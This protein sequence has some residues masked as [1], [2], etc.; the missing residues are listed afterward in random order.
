[1]HGQTRYLVRFPQLT[2]ADFNLWR[3]Y[4]DADFDEGYSRAEFVRSPRPAVGATAPPHLR[5]SVPSASSASLRQSDGLALTASQKDEH[6]FS[7]MY[8]G[9]R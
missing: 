6:P 8:S 2:D 3:V 4:A 1:M 5:D 9:Q 7:V